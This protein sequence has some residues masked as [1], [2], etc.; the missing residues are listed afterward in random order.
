M[1]VRALQCEG[2]NGEAT[3]KDLAGEAAVVLVAD[4]DVADLEL[5]GDRWKK[6]VN[7]AG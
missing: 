4:V 3:S 7:E 6:E 2:V 1:F 5:R